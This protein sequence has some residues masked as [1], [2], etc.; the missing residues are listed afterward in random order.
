MSNV[1]VVLAVVVISIFGEG[2]LQS[3]SAGEPAPG[4]KIAVVRIEDAFNEYQRTKEWKTKLEAEFRPEHDEIE[5]VRKAIQ[6]LEREMLNDR[7]LEPGSYVKFAKENEIVKKK[8]YLKKKREQVNRLWND[9]MVEFYKGIYADF[10]E[11]V[12]RYAKQNKYDLVIR[13][14]DREL[15]HES[16]V[17]VQNEITV[18]FLHYYAPSLDRTDQIVAV[19][20]RLYQEKKAKQKNQLTPAR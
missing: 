19:M 4:L 17:G 10:Q 16:F 11:A 18:K 9:V 2:G 1:R 3:A 6:K 13:A 14:A 20:N 7:T 8:Y 5:S 12:D 15:S